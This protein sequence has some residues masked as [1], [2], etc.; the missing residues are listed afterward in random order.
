ME[1]GF[2]P[3]SLS[4]NYLP[5]SGVIPN[6]DEIFVMEQEMRN[7]YVF[8]KPDW[9]NISL[10]AIT[11]NEDEQWQLTFNVSIKASVANNLPVGFHSGNVVLKGQAKYPPFNNWTNFTT[12]ALPITL[13]VL[14]FTPLSISPSIFT[15][16]HV[17]G[18]PNPPANYCRIETSS[19]WSI[20]PSENW[21]T[22]SQY[23]GTGSNNVALF[24]DTATLPI[25]LSTAQFLVD[26]GRTQKFGT[27]HVNVTGTSSEDYTIV[28]PIAL[29]FSETYGVV[30]T[31]VRAF[32]IDTT[33]A[34]TLAVDVPWLSLSHLSV[35]IGYTSVTAS[36]QATQ[37]MAVG[38][39]P[40]KITVTTTE[41]VT[42]VDVLLIIVAKQFPDIKT[43]GFYFAD[44]RNKIMLT[45]ST[46]NQQAVVTI[47]AQGP[48]FGVK[49]Y[50]RKVPYYR[51][52]A[53]VVVG[54]E[55]AILLQKAILPPLA[56]VFY[57]AIEPVRYDFRIA[58]QPLTG[59]P[60]NPHTTAIENTHFINGT[61]PPEDLSSEVSGNILTYLPSKITVPAD[62]FLAFSV[63]STA[64]I[65]TCKIV[66][67]QEAS[68]VPPI[69]IPVSVPATD[70][71][72]AI[73]SVAQLNLVA[74]DRALFTFG[75]FEFEIQIKPTQ[76]AT[77][78]I[79]WEN[80]WDLPEIYNC[81]GPVEIAV[82]QDA[83]TVTFSVD[84]Q[85]YEK[86]IATKDPKEFSLNTGNIYTTAEREFLATLL[87]AKRVWVEINGTRTEVI[88][89]TRNIDTFK[90][91]EFTPTLTLK[92][93]SAVV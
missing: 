70:I 69:N 37:A 19:S 64:T 72:T 29:E 50:V 82:L 75:F 44:D 3:V 2:N 5:H 54:L 58:S 14:Q 93:K 21:L 68:D 18:D 27:V 30:P 67:I 57:K 62:G 80:E 47:K 34:A 26:D 60:L 76:L 74:G 9:I 52:I 48:A 81:T 53:S 36:T 71:Y 79:I 4:F 59:L 31:D 90:T 23:N 6:E 12:N 86:V 38:T 51:N 46:G 78:Q 11:Q 1:L 41:G 55:T 32:T 15:I 63:R 35:P 25:G 42:I 28:N 17:N 13:R 56:T 83:E 39:Y 22:F 16:Q 65:A 85:D 84:G 91:R 61:T 89:S 49:N 73:F 66:K 88:S 92:F 87:K 77:T 24:V 20:V 40:G 45:S 10:G 33:L 7:M 8:Q 43:N